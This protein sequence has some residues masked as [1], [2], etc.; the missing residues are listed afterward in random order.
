MTNEEVAARGSQAQ[1]EWTEL[2]AAFETVRT[3][4]LSEMVATPVV[5]T[6]K[7][8]RLH[9]AAQNLAAVKQAIRNVIDH[10]LVARRALEGTGLNSPN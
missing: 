10:G 3:A 4:I 1:R 8:L 2:E 7:V 5:Q 9:A 6:D